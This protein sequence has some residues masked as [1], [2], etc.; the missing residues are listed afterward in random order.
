MSSTTHLVHQAD[1]DSPGSSS[2][3]A[4]EDFGDLDQLE[5]LQTGVC[6]R[7]GRNLLIIVSRNYPAKM[8]R[9]DRVYR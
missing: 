4:P 3:G 6:D 9:T 5:F 8:L 2:G 7:T 1:K